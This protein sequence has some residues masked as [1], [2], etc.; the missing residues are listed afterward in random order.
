M[1]DATTD[2]RPETVEA[3]PSQP[4]PRRSRRQAL[5]SRVAALCTAERITAAFTIVLA[6]ATLAL[7]GTAWFQHNDAV[8]AIT[9]TQRLAEATENAA[10][11]RR[12][13]SSA[14]LILKFNDLLESPHYAKIVGDIE[15]HSSNYPLL[16]RAKKGRLSN[17][18]D[19]DVEEY[20]GIFED[21]GYFIEDNLIIAKMVYDHF[22]Y[23]IEKAWCNKDVQRIVKEARAADKSTTANVDPI[24]G[25]FEKL[26]TQYLAKEHQTCEDMETQ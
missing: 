14:E 3:P 13:I 24:Y 11:D 25:N 16:P 7:V 4:S 2:A 20:I 5:W 18:T 12:K 10:T 1:T 22:S 17:R 8:E 15:S 9:A 21:M 23:D 26:A 19:A 6:S